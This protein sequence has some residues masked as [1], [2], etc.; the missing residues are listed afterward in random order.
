MFV[1]NR[2]NIISLLIISKAY[3]TKY[4]S[5][6]AIPSHNIISTMK[7]KT[8]WN[9]KKSFG[10]KIQYY[11]K[12]KG[13]T[14][15]DLAKAIGKTEE[16]VSN[17]ERGLNSTTLESIEQIAQTLSIDVME[18]F[19]FD[20]KQKIKDR[21]KFA[22]IKEVNRLLEKKDQKFIKGLITLINQ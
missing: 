4:C 18:F 5:I 15:S 3:Y 8:S 16:T 17:I 19:N 22:L 6:V 14:Q 12:L 21:E 20:D 10:K 2:R 13:L 7:N 11:R 9:I 1:M